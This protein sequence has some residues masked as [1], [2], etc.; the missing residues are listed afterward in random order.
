MFIRQRYDITVNTDT[1]KT[2]ANHIEY[3]EVD[4]K[5]LDDLQSFGQWLHNVRRNT[6]K[7]QCEAIDITYDP[8]FSFTDDELQS[9]KTQGR[10]TVG[11]KKSDSKYRTYDVYL[12]GKRKTW[13]EEI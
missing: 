4:P 13:R 3:H 8:N 2:V 11:R 7:T 5:L 1:S 12:D 10:L 6:C 9:L